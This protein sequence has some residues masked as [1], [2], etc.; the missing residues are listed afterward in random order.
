MSPVIVHLNWRAGK[1]GRMCRPGVGSVDPN[2][3]RGAELRRWA[4]DSGTHNHPL[5]PLSCV[6]GEPTA[7]PP[8][9]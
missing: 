1:R 7:S 4:G 2:G 6:A 9:T 3:V 5:L 8:G